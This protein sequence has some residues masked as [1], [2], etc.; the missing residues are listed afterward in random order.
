MKTLRLTVLLLTTCFV[1]T[2]ANAQTVWN[3]ITN[4]AANTNWSTPGNW[5]AGLPSSTS[6]ALFGDATGVTNTTVP[7]NVVDINFTVSALYITNR[8]TYQNTLIQPNFTL[9]ITGTPGLVATNIAASGVTPATTNTISGAGAALVINNAS[10][11]LA[12]GSGGSSG[13]GPNT[14]DLSGLDTFTMTGAD[15]FSGVGTSG[16][17]TPRMSGVLNLAKTN[18]ITLTGSSPQI[19]VG[20][21]GQNTGTASVLNLGITNTIFANTL[22][23]GIEKQGSTGSNSIIRF[24]PA[25]AAM[26]PTAAAYFRASDGVSPMTSWA[27]ADGEGNTGSSTAPRGMIDF[28]GGTVN[29]LVNSIWIGKPSPGSTSSP[30]GNGTLI[31]GAGVLTVNNLTN[32]VTLSGSVGNPG[33]TG[34]VNVTNNGVNGPGTL[35]VNNDLVMAAKGAA[36]GTATAT[37]NI[38]GGSTVQAN[39]IVA[40]G[41]SATINVNNGTLIVTNTAGTPAT[42]LAALSVGLTGPAT[43]LIFVSGSVAEIDVTN[44][45]DNVVGTATINIGALPVITSYPKQF[46]L[47]AYS[48]FSGTF[49]FT[50]GTLPAGSPAFAGYISNNVANNSVDL[51]LTSGPLVTALFQWSGAANNNWDLTST[52]WKLFGSATTYSNTSLVVFDDSTTV[53]NVNLTTNLSPGGITMSNSVNPYIFTG[54]GAL[55]GSGS[56]TLSGAGT[57]VVANSGNNQFSGGVT[58]NSGTLQF[59]NGGSNGNFPSGDAVTDNGH[60]VFD[61][62]NNA[63]VFGAVSGTGNVVQNGSGVVTMT[64]SNSYAGPTTVNSGSLIVDGAIGGGGAVSSAAGTV[65]GGSGTIYGAVS[66]TGQINPGDPNFVGTLT[67]SN[68]VTLP[69]G[70]NLKFD[71]STINLTPGNGANDLLQIGGNLTLNNNVIGVDIQGIPSPGDD[72]GVISYTGTLSGSFNPTVVGTHYNVTID[73]TSV[74]NFVYLEILS[75]TGAS[76]KWN[77]TSSGVWDTGTSNWFNLTTLQSDFYGNGDFVVLDDSVAGAQTNLTIAT[78]QFIAPSSITNTGAFNYTI[79]GGGTITGATALFKDG[80][81]TLR[82]NTTNSYTGG[83][84]IVNGTVV[85]GVQTALGSIAPGTLATI[86]V[87]N[88]GTLELNGQTLKNQ[89]AF[90][91]GAGVGNNGAVVNSTAGG[92]TLEAITLESDTTLGGNQDWRIANQTTGIAT[93]NTPAT[94]PLSLTKTGTNQILLL[95]C[96]AAD[97]DISN[98]NV[99]QG[100]FAIQGTPA[101]QSTQLGDPNGTLTISS[102]ANVQYTTLTVPI[103]KNILLDDGGILWTAGG[104]STNAG[105]LILTNNAANTGPGTGIV[106]NNGGTE[107]VIQSVITGPGNLLKTGA[108][109]T[110]L[111]NINTNTGDIIVNAGTLALDD[112][113]AISNSAVVTIASGARLDVSARTDD[114]FELASGQTLNGGG[115]VRGNLTEDAGATVEPGSSSAVGTLTVTNTASLAGTTVMKLNAGAGTNDE[116]IA[117]QGITNGGTLT[118]TNVNGTITAGQVFTLFSSGSYNGAF[119]VTN[120]PALGGGLSWNTANLGVNGTLSVAGSSGPTTNA[121]ITSVKVSAGN[122]IIVGTNNNV[123]NTNFHY[124]VLTSTN[125]ATALSNWTSLTTNPFNPDGTFDYTNAINPA[126][127]RLFYDVKVVP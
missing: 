47:I 106:T 102:N 48:T 122:I 108:G 30:I 44:L 61:L 45:T 53:T 31:M 12:A 7:N 78:G 66:A 71:L 3:A 118:V 67:V 17:S 126:T 124:A 51:V 123:P 43:N 16:T 40:G 23:V 115:T 116:L 86:T 76:L 68:N 90:L 6:A 27:I 14:L 113:G 125:I 58:I 64:A 13:S 29:A 84:V 107:L 9:N 41:G 39:T 38:D 52:D 65:L 117:S 97:V 72:W 119:A 34:T 83:T 80:S 105:A 8:T 88:A 101:Q 46:P 81:G 22:A 26:S 127:P 25:F 95:G 62:N 109:T 50:L 98:V 49:N 63:P 87:S 10:A 120:L 24:N 85:P 74:P 94:G 73:T 60:L 33:A 56:L 59:G 104:T 57:L 20:D 37:L 93:M 1:A 42:P 15:M 77:S 75:G 18:V 69:S 112:L 28:S 114:T 11:I 35:I 103:T 79:S 4:V 91:S 36:G 111:E 5:S 89:H 82:I 54:S 21:N 2:F 99:T 70:G 32:A 100:S 92:G 110:L 55:V 19:D 121:N 96:N